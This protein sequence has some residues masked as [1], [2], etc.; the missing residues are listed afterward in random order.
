MLALTASFSVCSPLYLPLVATVL[1]DSVSLS[2]SLVT[3]APV[4][5]VRVVLDGVYLLL[6]NQPQSQSPPSHSV[7]V[8]EVEWLEFTLRLCNNSLLNEDFQKVRQSLYNSTPIMDFLMS[9]E[10]VC[11]D[12]RCES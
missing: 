7:C 9:F 1:L 3:G 11:K 8:L 5:V 4:Q 2:T 10:A 6:A 12:A